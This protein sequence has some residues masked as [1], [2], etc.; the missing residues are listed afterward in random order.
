MQAKLGNLPFEVSS[1]VG[2]STEIDDLRSALSTARLVT[3]TGVGGAGKSRLAL[4]VARKLRA[5]LPDGAWLVE[6][7]QVDD[8]KLLAAF[9]LSVFGVP[10]ES[11]RPVEKALVQWLADKKLLLVLDN[12]EHLVGACGRLVGELL[13]SVPGVRILATTREVLGVAGEVI[14]PIPAL[15]LPRAGAGQSSATVL[16]Y[17]APRLFGERAQAALPGFAV[18]DANASAVAELCR[19][20]DG[21]A[22]AV[23]LAAVQLRALSLGQILDRVDRPLALLRTGRSGSDRRHSLRAVVEGSFGLCAPGEQRIWRTTSVF[24]GGFD[25]PAAEAVCG[26]SP[27]GDIEFL[28]SLSGLVDKSVLTVSRHGETTRYRMLE[29]IRQYGLEKL[30]EAGEESTARLR[31][32][33]HYLAVAQRAEEDWSGAGQPELLAYL[34]HDRPNLWSALDFSV[35]NPGEEPFAVRLAGLLWPLWIVGGFLKE[36]CYWVERA[37][38]AEVGTE[39]D[40]V[41]AASVGALVACLE[42]DVPRARC[43]LSGIADA[44][45]AVDDPAV[46]AVATRAAGT[47]E[48]IDGKLEAARPFFDETLAHLKNANVPH[49]LALV[50]YADLGVVH[51]LSGAFELGMARCEEGREICQ[52][53]GETWALSW[54]LFVQSFMRLLQ[55]EK[56]DVTAD[57]EGMLRIKIAFDDILGILQAAELLAWVGVHRDAR[58]AA[59]ILGA[60][61]ALWRPLGAYLMSFKPYLARHERSLELAKEALGEAAFEREFRAGAEMDLDQL[62]A[63]VLDEPIPTEPR[64]SAAGQED[65]LTAR[66]REICTMVAEGLTDREIADR[67]VLSPRTV[68]T[69]VANV[70]AKL[71]FRSRVQIAAWT[72]T[73]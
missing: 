11:G 13:A 64:T 70:L 63:F 23:E 24:V 8:E 16:E 20:L 4:E 30:A 42:G 32:R 58:R 62:V 35:S 43:I 3:V 73:Q 68:Q 18:T 12:C 26:A 67:L 71:G 29:T 27:A 69:H 31:H 25:L 19:R 51:S 41:R 40:R 65:L 17:E 34:R 50:S 55:D 6:L 5:G 48:M 7:E 36:G 46:L 54:I 39:A 52:A 53:Q 66:E 72:T 1:F 44:R 28:S 45:D 47:V 61:E 56:D 60:N 57:L 10:V 14:W 33:D 22:L 9:V 21:N 2:R 15:S 49:S 59:R 37:L 38:R